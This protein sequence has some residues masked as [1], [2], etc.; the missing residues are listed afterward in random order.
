M[1]ASTDPLP[2]DLLWR[3][4]EEGA[5]GLEYLHE[6]GYV[7]RDVKSANFLL[8]KD[9]TLKIADF[10]LAKELDETMSTV[11]KGTVR[12]MAPEVIE[13]LKL[14]KKSDVYSYGVV[15]WEICTRQR[16][17]ESFPSDH[18][19]MTAV[20]NG[21]RP[22]IPEDC[23]AFLQ[24]IIRSCWQAKHRQRPTMH[25]IVK[26]LQEHKGGYNINHYF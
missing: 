25:G 19:V 12:W 14:S 13:D 18:A 26:M 10:G 2:D 17:F 4:I 20:C 15:I 5:I 3:W 8:T 21:E 16:P 23:P 7:H 11:S 1:R 22:H 6:N 9:D 24:E